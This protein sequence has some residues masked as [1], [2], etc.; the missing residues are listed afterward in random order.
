MKFT[1]VTYKK[2]KS[3]HIFETKKKTGDIE[4]LLAKNFQTCL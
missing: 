1:G 4:N 2:D 3:L